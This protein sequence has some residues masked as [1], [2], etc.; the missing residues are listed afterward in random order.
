VK[1]AVADSLVEL[2]ETSLEPDADQIGRYVRVVFKHATPEMIVSLRAF[3]P[4]AGKP[5]IFIRSFDVEDDGLDYIIG[6]AIFGA[7]EAAKKGALFAPP[8]ATF[9]DHRSA[10]FGNLAE[11]VVVSVEC[12]ERAQQALATLTAILGPPTLVVASGGIW[13][14]PETG[15]G[16]DKLHLYWRLAVPARDIDSF[17]KLMEA[18]KI[19]TGLVGADASN[20]IVHPLRWPGSWH[21]KAAPRLCRIVEEN[22]DVEVDLDAALELLRKAAPPELLARGTSEAKQHRNAVASG[23]TGRTHKPLNRHQIFMLPDINEVA[24]VVRAIPNED[25]HRN[26]WNNTG[27]AI[28]ASTGGSE[29]GHAIFLEFSAK[30]SKHH[31]PGTVR[32]RWEGMRRSPP[33][34]TGW[35]KLLAMARANGW[36]PKLKIG[37][38]T[39]KTADD[40]DNV[41][42]RQPLSFM[43]GVALIRDETVFFLDEVVVNKRRNIRIDHWIETK[44]GPAVKQPRRIEGESDEKFWARCRVVA[45]SIRV[46]SSRHFPD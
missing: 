2:G 23:P 8:V 40:D 16:E 25:L 32:A 10:S 1:T 28:F 36:Q 4:E 22:D 41:V 15:L 46:R 13:V 45:V 33:T 14:N 35:G 38:P 42:K 26:E 31:N 7:R 24:S 37:E 11:G 9:K 29:E 20:T 19:A 3:P 18:L 27:M 30:S 21:L 17:A 43:D 39:A 34:R 5:P 6:G 44:L 12:D